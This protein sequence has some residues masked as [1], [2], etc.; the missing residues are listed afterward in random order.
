MSQSVSRR[1]LI[2]AGLA[3]AAAG[4]GLADSPIDTA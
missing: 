1:K 2:T 4:S 3:T